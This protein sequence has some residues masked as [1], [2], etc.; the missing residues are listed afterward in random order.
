MFT[1]GRKCSHFAEYNALSLCVC[2]P[3]LA[4]CAADLTTS[5]P[6][7]ALGFEA[8]CHLIVSAL[9]CWPVYG[10]TR[11]LFRFLLDSLHSTSLP[12]SGPK[13]TFS[14]LCLMVHNSYLIGSLY[15]FTV[16]DDMNLY[17][18]VVYLIVHFFV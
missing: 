9:S 11:G 15:S 4:A 5:Y 7:S 18:E 14:L 10:W 3:K 13:E 1:F 16:P 17:A 6:D 2:S 12:A 8:V